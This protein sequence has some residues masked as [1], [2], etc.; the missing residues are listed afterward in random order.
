MA[1]FKTHLLGGSLSV[2]VSSVLL[3][4]AGYATTN[5]ALSYFGVGVVGSLLPDVDLTT[6]IPVRIAQRLV[7]VIGTLI[8]ALNYST[9]VSLLEVAVISIFTFFVFKFGFVLFGKYTKHR[10]LFH[11]VPMMVLVGFITCWLAWNVFDATNTTSWFAG[12]FM[13]LGFATHL[14]LDEAYSV[15]L[16]GARFKRS[17][18]T[19]IALGDKKNWPGT[20]ALYLLLIAVWGL[21]PSGG[22]FWNIVS[23][24]ETY[25]SMAK[26]L[27]P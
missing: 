10:G 18:G 4:S 7:S 14:I 26:Q 24:S 13:V 3:S 23:D 27:V 15:N 20:I 22:N 12:L 17:F 19:A 1:D 2:G 8:V 25:A 21:L 9:R 11:S 16:L 6:S 5:E